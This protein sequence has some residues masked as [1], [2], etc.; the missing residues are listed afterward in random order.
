M[1]YPDQFDFE[2]TSAYALSDVNAILADIAGLVPSVKSLRTD[3]FEE[4]RVCASNH[5]RIVLE[6]T[7]DRHSFAITPELTASK[8]LP[9]AKAFNLT[10]VQVDHLVDRC[11]ALAEL[12]PM[13]S[14]CIDASPVKPLDV[15]AST[16]DGKSIPKDSY[17]AETCEILAEEFTRVGV[18]RTDYQITFGKGPTG[19]QRRRAYLRFLTQDLRREVAAID[20]S[21][22][23]LHARQQILKSD[24][25]RKL[26]A[27]NLFRMKFW[28][29]QLGCSPDALAETIPILSFLS[30]S[31]H[32]TRMQL[33]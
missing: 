7:H 6:T 24:E 8:P 10:T 15:T 20:T 25:N 11:L 1:H 28:S 16:V 2:R 13:G 18:I 27:L 17:L 23:P 29:R 26:L 30:S 21:G 3:R 19:T 9:L 33:R 12:N 31:L 14:W 22:M 4:G 32:I 5:L